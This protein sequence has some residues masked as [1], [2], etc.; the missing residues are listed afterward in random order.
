MTCRSMSCPSIRNAPG[1]YARRVRNECRWHNSGK[2]HRSNRTGNRNVLRQT[3][4]LPL[5]RFSDSSDES[6]G[7][8]LPVPSAR[9]QG[10]FRSILPVPPSPAYNH[11]LL[12]RNKPIPCREKHRVS[13][14]IP[15]PQPPK[16][17]PGPPSQYIVQYP[18]IRKINR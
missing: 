14:G 11:G 15:R 9:Q 4:S 3:V 2:H 6:T 5:S 1:K 10:C 13:P 17:G 16:A 8:T 12:L 7:G 18:Y